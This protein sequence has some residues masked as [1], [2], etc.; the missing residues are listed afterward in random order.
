MSQWLFVPPITFLIVL[1]VTIIF[2]KLLGRLAFR[3][4][5]GQGVDAGGGREG[6]AFQGVVQVA[7]I[8]EV[9]FPARDQFTGLHDSPFQKPAPVVGD[10]GRGVLASRE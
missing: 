10:Q 4:K 5:G 8:V 6:P 7:G 1:I 2:T 9:F 3:V